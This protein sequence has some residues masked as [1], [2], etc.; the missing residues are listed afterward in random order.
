MLDQGRNDQLESISSLSAADLAVWNGDGESYTGTKPVDG[1]V[2]LAVLL[3]EGLKPDS[4]VLEIGCGMLHAGIPIM[5]FLDPDGYCAIDPNE[6]LRE[7]TLYHFGHQA[8]YADRHPRFSSRYDF[9]GSEFGTRF[10]YVFS[11]SVL[12]HA[13]V[14]HFGE[15]LRNT[16]KVLA[17]GGKIVTSFFLAE[18]GPGP[19]SGEKRTPDG[20][21]SGETEW[22]YPRRSYFTW[23]T[24]QR[25]AWKAGLSVTL[26]PEYTELVQNASLLHHPAPGHCHDWLV[27]TASH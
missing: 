8:L 2:H 16:K 19:I 26:K 6:W 17:P 23:S 24:V 20:R 9:D 21:D 25:E 5:G 4:K 1:E 10:D 15:Y 14:S 27:L 12:S 3:A 18:S 11:H 7:T 22:V 13:G